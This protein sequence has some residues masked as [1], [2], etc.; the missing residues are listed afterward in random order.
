MAIMFENTQTIVVTVLT[1]LLGG[2][3]IGALINAYFSKGKTKAEAEKTLSE[4][5]LAYAN[6]LSIDMDGLR[7]VNTQLQTDANNLQI[8]LNES[9]EEF[10]KMEDRAQHLQGLVT[11][12]EKRRADDRAIIEKLLAALHATDPNNV[13]ITELQ[14]LSIL[15]APFHVVSGI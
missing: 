10:D 8:R 3:T 12:L 2:G 9:R 11:A 1:L 14:K 15:Q 7:K 4:A 6:K 5:I 13:V